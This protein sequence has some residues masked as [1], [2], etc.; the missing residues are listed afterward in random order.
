[1]KRAAISY[2]MRRAAVSYYETAGAKQGMKHVPKT[3]SKAWLT[4]T[5]V[6]YYETGMKHFAR[7]FARGG[8]RNDGHETGV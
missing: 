5:G 4:Q 2:Y 7:F 3:Q 8:S 1:M 6:P